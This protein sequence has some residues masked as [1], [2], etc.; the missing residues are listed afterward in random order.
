MP[1]QGLIVFVF[2][3]LVGV[4]DLYAGG[5]SI[6]LFGIQRNAM[7]TVVAS[8]YDPTAIYHNPAGIADLP[9]IQVNLSTV[10]SY[11]DISY[12]FYM[13]PDPNHPDYIDPATMVFPEG[14][15]EKE[16]SYLAALWQPKSTRPLYPPP[17]ED[18]FK[19]ELVIAAC[20]SL[21][22]SYN[23]AEV[24]PFLTGFS[25]GLGIYFPAALGATIGEDN[26]GRFH[27][28]DG[29][30]I[31]GNIT[32]AVGWRFLE[33]ISIGAGLRVIYVTLEL[34]QIMNFDMMIGEDRSRFDLRFAE[35]NNAANWRTNES[36]YR[37][38]ADGD[39]VLA[40]FNVG[41]LFNPLS[42]FAL[43]ICFT[44]G[45]YADIKGDLT[46]NNVVPG[47][48]YSGIDM[49]LA[50]THTTNYV[51]PEN[52]KFGLHFIPIQWME[53]GLD[54]YL[55]FY[56]LI[57]YQLTQVNLDKVDETKKFLYQLALTDLSDYG[58]PGEYGLADE[59]FYHLSHTL[60]LGFL[61]HAMNA[62]DWDGFALDVM[63]GVQY[64]WS[65]FH[66]ETYS[67]F[68]PGL[69]CW[70]VSIGFQI[71][72]YDFFSITLSTSVWIYEDVDV[73]EARS[74]PP[75]NVQVE[76]LQYNSHIGMNFAFDLSDE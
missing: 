65:P 74:E 33:W 68:S 34:N 4:S 54:Y 29:Y 22:L 28:T 60:S 3:L 69:N 26:P 70:A 16:R 32:L 73:I 12:R 17:G 56:N 6:T 21:M 47:G 46:L 53:I 58:K 62:E 37:M 59:K 61:F 43:G 51:V 66:N 67:I 25:I 8:P 18:P 38:H 35:E 50:T 57:D 40:G 27:L 45:E 63:T 10:I 23:F 15:D 55:F 13:E 30:F 31:S 2:L 24:H 36:N 42:W 7:G 19:P 44:S 1:K 75:T 72:L 9:G 48:T 5:Y 71:V 52:L 76:V 64:D 41:V 14:I 20:P 11:N 49:D 39:D